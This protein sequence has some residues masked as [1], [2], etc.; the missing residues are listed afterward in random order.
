LNELEIDQNDI[1]EYKE[2]L[3][4]KIKNDL[5]KNNGLFESDAKNSF[6][7]ILN[8]SIKTI[9]IDN[10]NFSMKGNDNIFIEIVVGSEKFY[11]N[12]YYFINN[13]MY[14]DDN[15]SDIISN[16]VEFIEIQIYKEDS[17]EEFKP[18]C[19]LDL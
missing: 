8:L 7:K 18:L 9:K 15:L 6:Y 5:N 16:N 4:K 2:F 1:N 14:I 3:S 12:N 10:E 17:K 19:S 11:S 13:L